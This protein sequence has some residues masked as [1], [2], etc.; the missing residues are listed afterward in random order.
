GGSLG[1]VRIIGKQDEQG[2]KT[3]GNRICLRCFGS[4][5]SSGRESGDDERGKILSTPVDVLIICGLKNQSVR[6]LCIRLSA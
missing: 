3:T 6:R 2:P 4:G 5:L 1:R